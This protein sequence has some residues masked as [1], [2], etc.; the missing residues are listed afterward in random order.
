MHIAS[1]RYVQVE[2]IEQL[3]EEVKV[4]KN[5]NKI[6]ITKN[7]DTFPSTETPKQNSKN[8]HMASDS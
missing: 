6:E 7:I 8:I 3:K 1:G 4:L 2:E 5:N